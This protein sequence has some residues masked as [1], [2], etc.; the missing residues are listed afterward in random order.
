MQI[1]RE[2][3]V[4][5]FK[6]ETLSFST[7]TRF[8]I[9]V[10][11]PPSKFPTSTENFRVLLNWGGAVAPPNPP[12]ISANGEATSHH[13]KVCVQAHL[14]YDGINHVKLKDRY[15][16]PGTPGINSYL[17]ALLESTKVISVLCTRKMI[18][19]LLSASVLES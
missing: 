12:I 5:S 3:F 15:C 2:H 14:K 7:A 6:I 10:S 13:E 4:C 18:C 8:F 11:I 19:G 16:N 17:C 1:E 9:A